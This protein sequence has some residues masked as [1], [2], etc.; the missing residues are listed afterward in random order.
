MSVQKA[1]GTRFESLLVSYLTECGLSAY[2]NA[3]S[4]SKDIG[5]ISLEGD[6]TLEAKDCKTITLSSFVDEANA[7]ARNAGRPYGAAVVKRRRRGVADAYVVMDLATFV[8]LIEDYH[9]ALDAA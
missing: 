4:G 1:K 3:P 8:T 5:D 7:E 9:S 2:R 6:V